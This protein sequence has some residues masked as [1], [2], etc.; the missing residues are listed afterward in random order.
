MDDTTVN[1][2]KLNYQTKDS[3]ECY[4]ARLA[5]ADEYSEKNKDLCPLFDGLFNER[6]DASLYFQ[7]V[8]GEEFEKVGPRVKLGQHPYPN[9]P[10]AH[11]KW[12]SHISYLKRGKADPPS[13]GRPLAFHHEICGELKELIHLRS[14]VAVLSSEHELLKKYFLQYL[15]EDVT[16]FQNSKL[17]ET[18]IKHLVVRMLWPGRTSLIYSN[19][20]PGGRQPK[21]DFHQIRI[22]IAGEYLE[23]VKTE[24]ARTIHK[25]TKAMNKKWDKF[26]TRKI[27]SSLRDRSYYAFAMEIGFGEPW[28]RTYFQKRTSMGMG[29]KD[30]KPKTG[31]G[32]A[33]KDNKKPEAPLTD[34]EPVDFFRLY[35]DPTRS[36]GQAGLDEP[37]DEEGSDVE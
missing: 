20:R 34:V 25:K 24:V 11:Q 1:I 14:G 31:K 30:Q 26:I 21:S 23:M 36:S 9:T 27:F 6:P 19:P 7:G 29:K 17:C 35:D 4:A 12:A 33:A 3:R 32:K 22:S 10:A 2:S 13:D 18:G 16:M 15:G 5:F 37:S 28:F 8:P